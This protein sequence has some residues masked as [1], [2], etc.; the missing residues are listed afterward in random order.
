MRRAPNFYEIDPSSVEI[1][2]FANSEIYS[3]TIVL[4]AANADSIVVFYLTKVKLSSAL[5]KL[6][7]CFELKNLVFN[8]QSETFLSS[9]RTSHKLFQLM[10]RHG[11]V[12]LFLLLWML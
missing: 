4:P 6:L 2:K 1:M 12:G 9:A 7:G 5:I 8:R 11:P 10:G 3:Q